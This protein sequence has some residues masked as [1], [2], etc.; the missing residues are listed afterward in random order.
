MKKIPIRCLP[1]ERRIGA[2]FDAASSSNLLKQRTY[3]HH[4]RC[5]VRE[6]SSHHP[7]P[8]LLSAEADRP[9]HGRSP[10]AGNRH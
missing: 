6:T 2:T 9:L 1:S 8:L 3:Q 7:V 10:D 4:R 5:G